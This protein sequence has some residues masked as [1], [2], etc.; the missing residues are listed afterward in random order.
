[1]ENFWDMFRAALLAIVAYD[2]LQN[3][4]KLLVK[5]LSKKQQKEKGE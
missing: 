5:Y 2:V 3:T 4:T 1:M